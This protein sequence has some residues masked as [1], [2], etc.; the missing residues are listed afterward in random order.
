VSREHSREHGLVGI[1]LKDHVDPPPEMTNCGSIF[2]TFRKLAVERAVAWT[3]EGPR[4]D[5]DFTLQ[6]D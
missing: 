2:V 4:G 6:D 1:L 3:R 5:E